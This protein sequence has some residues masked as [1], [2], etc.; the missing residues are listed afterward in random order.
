MIQVLVV[1]NSSSEVWNDIHTNSRSFIANYLQQFPD[2]AMVK[3]AKGQVVNTELNGQWLVGR[4]EVVD[5]SLAQIFFVTENRHEWIYRGSTRLE[6]LF[7]QVA[8]AEARKNQGA[9]RPTHNLANIHK[10]R[11]AP[12]VEY[13]RGEA[14]RPPQPPPPPPPLMQ[15]TTQTP[16]AT[17]V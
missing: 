13:T 3:L 6:P 12:Y 15:T 2:R 9:T 16:T 4:V 5:A 11:N 8:S 7:K 14:E 17:Q 1:C 10:R